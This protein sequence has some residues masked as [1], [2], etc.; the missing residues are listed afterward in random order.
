MPADVIEYHIYVSVR[1][2][3]RDPYY[4]RGTTG[5][6]LQGLIRLDKAGGVEPSRNST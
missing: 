4:Y 1:L 3:V 6:D 5:L 2:S